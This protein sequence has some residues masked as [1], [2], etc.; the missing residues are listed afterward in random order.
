M[1]WKVPWQQKPR[2]SADRS[3]SFYSLLRDEIG[4]I[5]RQG[6]PPAKDGESF[7]R[8]VCDLCHRASPVSSLR[9]CVICGRWACQDCWRD[10]LYVCGSCSG[11]IRLY[12]M[13]IPA[14]LCQDRTESHVVQDELQSDKKP[15]TSEN[16]ME[17]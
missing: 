3:G 7:S 8:Y 11:I 5:R 12:Q 17:G 14:G 10:D 13:P 15:E 2:T 4:E 1:P 9:Q 6:D 16:R